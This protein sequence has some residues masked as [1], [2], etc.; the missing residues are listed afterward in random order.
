MH[1][2]FR[3]SVDEELDGLEEQTTAFYTE[4]LQGAYPN[5]ESFEAVFVNDEFNAANEL[6]VLIDFDANA[7][8]T[9][10]KRG[11]TAIRFEVLHRLIFL[12]SV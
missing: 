10:G 5:L 11:R 3:R 8:F 12:F 9:E 7:F 2:G 4:I 1:A 6:P